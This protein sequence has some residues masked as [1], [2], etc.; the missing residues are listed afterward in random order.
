MTFARTFLIMFAAWLAFTFTFAR[1]ELIIGALAASAVAAITRKFAF[2]RQ[3]GLEAAHVRLLSALKFAGYFI[4]AEVLSHISV[5]KA[6]LSGKISPAILRLDVK[7]KTATGNT[8]LSSA[9]TLTPGT[10]SVDVGNNALYIHYL[11]SGG[12]QN[13][14]KNFGVFAGKIFGL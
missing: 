13:V 10:L 7:P 3:L 9:I 14:E 6:V 2:E 12:G 4:Y 1:N 11:D 8:F 5:A